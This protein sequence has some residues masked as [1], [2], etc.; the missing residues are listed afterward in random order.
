MTAGVVLVLDRFASSYP[1]R[2]QPDELPIG[3]VPI[4]RALCNEF[5]WDAHVVAYCAPTLPRRLGMNDDR[6]GSGLAIWDRL[7]DDGIPMALFIADVDAKTSGATMCAEWWAAEA[8]KVRAAFT[9]Q[10][11]YAYSTRGGYRL[12]WSLAQPFVIRTPL[13]HAVWKA[14]YLARLELLRTRYGIV[15]DRACKDFTRLYRLPRVLRDGERTALTLREVGSPTTIGPWMASVVVGS[16]AA[17]MEFTS[18]VA[19]PTW[20]DAIDLVAARKALAAYATKQA[21]SSDVKAPRRVDIV[22]RVLES[23]A[24]VDAE[25]LG[26]QGLGRDNTVFEAANLI[27]WVCPEVGP[28]G[29]AELVFMSIAAM[30]C[31]AS[32]GKGRDAYLAKARDVYAASVKR[33]H[34]ARAVGRERENKRLLDL[35]NSIVSLP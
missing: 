19:E 1:K 22:R 5:S 9:D 3:H 33:L 4:E 8:S 28:Y 2:V 11:G 14:T 34:Q 13:E 20:S 25:N 6:S 29:C 7:P 18:M 26:A 15:A 23:R 24:L 17:G 21:R 35:Y 27:G 16:V 32:N 30:E 12:V 31:D 10:P